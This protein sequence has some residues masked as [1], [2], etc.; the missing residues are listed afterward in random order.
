MTI[1]IGGFAVLLLLSG[2][3][4]AASAGHIR[5]DVRFRETGTSD[6]DA[7]GGTGSVI[8]T[9]RGVS[10]G[11]LGLEGS[12]RTV[13]TRRSSGVFTIVQDGGESRIAMAT[14]VPVREVGWFHD[15]ATG[16][17]YLSES[18][19]FENVGTSLKV[20]ANRLADGSIRVSLV[21]SVSWFSAER[22]G[23]IDFTE[24]AT[25]LVVAPGEEVVIGGGTRE[26]S[27]I[28]RRV[29]G[30]ERVS[31][32]GESSVVLKATPQ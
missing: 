4:L 16:G 21:P 22:A 12:S 28:T 23:A 8:I 2:V 20:R 30:I 6:R 31:G 14:R 19:T 17:G 29:L 26:L 13:K 9:E 27:E 18:I 1:R 11:A 24:A 3:S 5:V 7:A 15:Y 10:R 32:A 25:E